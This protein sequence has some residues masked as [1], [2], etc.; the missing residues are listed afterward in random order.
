MQIAPGLIYAGLAG[1]TRWPS[2][3]RSTN[4]LWERIIGMHLGSNY[5]LSTLR[6]TLGAILASAGHV[7]A[8]DEAALTAWMQ[9][10]LSVVTVPFVDAD[11]LGRIEDD[12]LRQLDPLFNLRGVSSSPVRERVSELRRRHKS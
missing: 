12:V 6:H 11:R 7:T 10:H 5:E 4:T 2:D 9:K 8:I 1:A 3:R